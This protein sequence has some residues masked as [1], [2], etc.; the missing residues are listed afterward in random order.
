MSIFANVNNMLF[1]DFLAIYRIMPSPIQ[2]KVLFVFFLMVF[3]AVFEACSVLSLSFLALSVTSPDKV[4]GLPL[5]SRIFA[6]FP[7]LHELQA[8]VRMFAL[9]IAVLVAA[10]TAAKNI[11]SGLVG[12]RTAVLGETVAQHAGDTL[13]QYYLN[14]PYLAYLAGKTQHVFQIISWRGQLGFFLVNLMQV[15]TYIFISASLFLIL[16][17]ATPEVLLITLGMVATLCFFIYKAIKRAV[18]VAGRESAEYS[19]VEYSALENAKRGMME[20]HIYRQQQYFFEA[21]HTAG[22]KAMPSRALITVAPPIPTW[23]LESIAFIVIPA[24]LWIMVTLYDASMTRITGVLTMIML[25]SWR[26][27]PLLN[28]SMTN[29]VALRGARYPALQCVELLQKIHED[30]LPPAE[31]AEERLEFSDGV[32]FD[33][34]SFCYPSGKQACLRNVSFKIFK[35]KSLGIIGQSGAGKSSLANIL[36]GLIA[37][38]SGRVLVDGRE[39]SSLERAAY[40]L[41]VGYVAQTPYLVPGTLAQ[42]VAFSQWGRPYDPEMVL[43]AC[44]LAHLDIVDTHAEGINLPIG[45]GGTGLSGGQGQRL[46]IARALYTSPHL[47]ILDEATSSLDLGVES[48]IMKTIASLPKSV[49]VVII[50]HRL[51]TVELCDALLWLKDGE[52]AMYGPPAVVLPSYKKYLDVFSTSCDV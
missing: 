49:T 30:P 45:E 42:N 44:R 39:L 9:W 11:M 40:M 31:K 6:A 33:D 13:F 35:G 4:M 46:S 43:H 18:D 41:G 3:L 17:S 25:A 37:P 14:S 50:A 34:V 32:V 23:I 2:R 38:T 1:K 15:Y 51:S 24:T 29:M 12:A 10:L 19:N 21:F 27:L 36:S 22:V 7:V 16:I 26:V 47:L 20:V 52:I 48:A 28:R 8:D 5:V